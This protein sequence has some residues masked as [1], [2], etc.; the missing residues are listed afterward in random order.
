MD[1]VLSFS[2]SSCVIRLPFLCVKFILCYLDLC[3]IN[4]LFCDT[5][6]NS[7]R[8]DWASL[9]HLPLM[10]YCQ[11]SS[12]LYVWSFDYNKTSSCGIPFVYVFLFFWR[13]IS[14]DFSTCMMLWT[15]DKYLKSVVISEPEITF[16][17]RE[18]DDECLILASD[19]LWDVLSSE[20]ACEVARECLQETV[21]ASSTTIDLNALP[22]IEE[23]AG[24]SYTSRSSVAAALLTRLA[25]GRKSTDNISVIV[26]DLKRS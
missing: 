8:L 23:G 6:D 18:P 25:L 1:I 9:L 4:N 2:L 26:I 19:G 13:L 17:K 10:L 5:S 24:T 11:A 16:T 12:E 22:Q 7:S 20:L 21:A 15:G 14:V 3:K